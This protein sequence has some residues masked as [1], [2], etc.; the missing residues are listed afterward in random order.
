MIDLWTVVNEQI[1]LIRADSTNLKIGDIYIV[2][3]KEEKY[4]AKLIHNL[5]ESREK[6]KVK[7]F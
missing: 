2:H 6:F 3:I 5:P 4:R 7:I 1:N